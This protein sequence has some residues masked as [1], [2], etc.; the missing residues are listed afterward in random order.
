M[1]RRSGICGSDWTGNHRALISG[2]LYSAQFAR[3]RTFDKLCDGFS[4]E[5]DAL[6]VGVRAD[7][8]NLS[9]QLLSALNNIRGESIF[10]EGN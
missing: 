8:T 9:E 3:F 6:R 4:D 10:R 5:R 7:G 2:Q 1:H